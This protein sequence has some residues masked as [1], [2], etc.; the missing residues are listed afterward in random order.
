ML[1]LIFLG[2]SSFTPSPS[3]LITEEKEPYTQ[4]DH[5]DVEVNTIEPRRNSSFSFIVS[6]THLLVSGRERRVSINEIERFRRISMQ[7]NNNAK[8]Q[9]SPDSEVERFVFQN[10]QVTSYLFSL[11]SVE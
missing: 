1:I 8:A 4:L 5:S 3:N 6:I 7:F 11:D 2:Y 10:L 9:I